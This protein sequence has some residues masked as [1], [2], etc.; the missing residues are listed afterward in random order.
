MYYKKT[1][2]ERP[3]VFRHYGSLYF[4]KA[5]FKKVKN[6]GIKPIGGFWASPVGNQYCT[7]ED[8]CRV[9]MP[10]WLKCPSCFIR[11][12]DHSKILYI[13]SIKQFEYLKKNYSYK[14]KRNRLFSDKFFL[15]HVIDYEKMVRDGFD[16]VYFGISAY[17]ELYYI[18]YG[19]DVDSLIVLNPDCVL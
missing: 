15:S 1:N 3:Y 14:N 7:W 9:E 18:L 4:S 13:D 17:P 19:F 6:D 11:L 12:K 10:D 2:I 8:F 16:A 5:K